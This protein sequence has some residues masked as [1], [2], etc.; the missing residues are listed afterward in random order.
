[1]KILAKNRRARFDYTILETFEAGIELLGSE[2]KSI[3][4]G[5]ASLKGSYV[6]IQATG[7]QRKL[8]AWLLNCNIAAYKF[9][10]KDFIKNY[11]TERSRKLLLHKKEINYL[12]GK[13]KEKGLTLVPLL[14]Y[15]SSR[16]IKV[17]ISIG[18][19]KKKIDKRD[20][21]QKRESKIRIGRAMRG[22]IE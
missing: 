22:K 14:L 7:P 3:R 12:A 10:G 19:G 13:Q 18:Q 16:K 9:A 6:V 15:T 11:D 21:I 17:K 5:Q 2:V 4:S 20:T 8:E 1:M